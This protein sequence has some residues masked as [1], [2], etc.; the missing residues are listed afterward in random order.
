MSSPK[1]SQHRTWCF[2]LNNPGATCT[3]TLSTLLD[4]P[5]YL[6]YQLEVGEQGTEHFQ[7]YVEFSKPKRLT[8]LKKLLPRAH[9]EPRKGTRLQAREYCMKEDT[10][11]EG[12]EPVEYGDFEAG[13]SGARNDLMDVKRKLDDGASMTT[14]ADEHFGSFL[15]YE[16]AFN[17][18]KRLKQQ[19]RKEKTQV[20][21]LTGPAGAGKSHWAREHFPNAYYK[22]NSKWWCGY[23]GQESVIFDDF[24]GWIPWS[25]LLNVCD[26]YPTMVETKGSNVNFTS[27]NIIITSNVDP[28]QWYDTKNNPGMKLEA[29]IR[30]I[31]KYVGFKLLGGD[32][33]T[34]VRVSREFTNFQEYLNYVNF[35]DPEEIQEALQNS[36]GSAV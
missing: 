5:R 34:G 35:T 13:G 30:R 29:L 9:W 17:S 26:A 21:V 33:Q 8:A 18:Y 27:K 22:Q 3:D 19:P 11:K 12:T 32:W 36:G 20:I 6:V 23:D 1:P 31:D 24:Y 10:R 4:F 28:S 7:G 2:T 16:K 25:V 14:I 15:R